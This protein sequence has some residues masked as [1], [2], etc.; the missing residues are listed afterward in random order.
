MQDRLSFVAGDFM[1][2]SPSD[3]KI[4]TAADGAGTYVIRHVLHDWDDSQ[5]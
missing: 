4:P 3:S 2:P 5:V 1:K